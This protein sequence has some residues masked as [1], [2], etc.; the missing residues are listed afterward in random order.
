MTF[1]TRLSAALLTALLL[2]CGLASLDA[3]APTAQEARAFL[4]DVDRELL[5]LS[6]A[7]NRA[8]WVQGTYIT[9][10]T[11]LIAADASEALI[12]ATTG[13]AKQAARFAQV[14]LPADERRKMTLLA[15][16]LT[17]AAPPDP[18]EAGELARLVT[19]MEAAY[20][21]GK[22]CPP[23]A[24]PARNGDEGDGCLD[25]EAI[26][27]I[28]AENRDATRLLEVWEGWH[29]VGT[30]MKKEYARFVELSNK[31]AATLGFADT[32]AMWRAKYDMPPEAFATELGRLWDQL[33]P[34]YL[35][36]HA[37][38]RHK[39]R[40]KYGNM[41]PEKGPI[42]A[43]LLG[44]LW[45]QDWSNIY[46]LVAPANTKAAYSLTDLLQARKVQPL[47]MVRYGERFFTSLGFDPLPKT[48]WERSLFLKPRDREVVCHA[49][50]WD[51]DNV[52]DL[53]I[54]MCIDVTAEDFTTIHHELGHNF[55]QRAYSHLPMIFR[56][57]ANDGF[58]EAVGDTLALSVTPEYLV[59]IGL[60]DK[61]PDASGDTALLL[62]SALDRLAF[63]PFGLLV[64]EW[65]WQVFSGKITPARR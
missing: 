50:A 6:N 27:K 46:P 9:P 25:I 62:Q 42:P 3:Q 58:H 65:R 40:D 35:S 43:H 24:Q 18:P 29:T 20:G 41:V 44:N 64:D 63:L 2:A 54:K 22:Y 15:N 59:Q 1:L 57:S 55:Y 61:A 33:R 48:F 37:Y 51:I 49:S 39:L 32:G 17:M 34:L 4:D 53:R 31:G 56:D 26:T 36:L 10:D 8:G 5:R 21:R 14:Q 19:A 45:Q 11:E 30:P 28:L 13:Y 38:V 7:N 52:D 16:S 23:G 12:R 60:L 47:D